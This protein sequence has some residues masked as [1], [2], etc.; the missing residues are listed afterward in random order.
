MPQT[1]YTRRSGVNIAYQ[2]TGDGPSDLVYVPGW[3]S[4]VEVM[5]EEPSMAQFLRRLSSFSRL[6]TFDKRGT[7]MSDPVPLEQLPT[8]EERMDD[9]SAVMDEV[10]SDRATLMGHSEGGNM[11][12]LFAATYPARTDRLVLV[13]SYAK[14]TWSE[15]Y[16][17]A[18]TPDQRAADIARTERDFGD[19][20]LLPEWLAPSRM[21]DPAFRQWI[22]RYFRLSSSPRAASHLLE[23][24]SGIDT[25]QVLPKVRVP[26]LLLYKT[27]DVDVTIEEGR[28]IASQIPDARLVEIPSADHLLNA[29]GSDLIADEIEE[30]MTGY[31]APTVPERALATVLFVDIVG[32]TDTAAR[33]GDHAWRALLERYNGIATDEVQRLRGR[34][35]GT[36]G[37][38][39]LAVFDGPG[40]AIRSAS[41]IIE[42]IAPLD[43]EVR[44]GVHTGEVELIGDDVA[45]IAVHIGSRIASLAEPG[46]I[47]VSRT[48]KDL[49]V[50]SHL[51]FE[52][53]GAHHLKG[54]PDAWELFAVV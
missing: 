54:V 19:P 32:S 36:Q 7:G 3:I 53:R 2:V 48:V 39:M 11:C 12:I 6:I 18:P 52:D 4:N 41:A 8:L 14:R 42:T 30:F 21:A 16:P 47:L 20:D 51:A 9:L 35:V 34:V 38:G 23:M 25:T 22:A 29:E 13:S 37:D 28:W 45:G 5:W 40:R 49:V 44:S 26:T 50:G 24:N 17:W 10:G 1:S 46:E 27:R 43:L 15:S 33:L 31:R